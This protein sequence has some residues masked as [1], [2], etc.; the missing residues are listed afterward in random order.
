LDESIH[1]EFVDRFDKNDIC[2][3][4]EPA[5]FAMCLRFRNCRCQMHTLQGGFVLIAMLCGAGIAD[6]AGEHLQFA[7]QETAI[8]SSSPSDSAAG[9]TAAE[10][11]CPQRI[12]DPQAVLTVDIQPVERP[13]LIELDPQSLPKECPAPVMAGAPTLFVGVEPASLRRWPVWQGA[14]FCHRPLYF[15]EACAERCGC[16]C[17]CAPAAS[18]AHFFGSAILLPLRM[19]RQCPGSCV[20]T[21][22]AF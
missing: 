2:L 15:E 10:N 8:D 13:G 4:L 12:D 20:C 21:P 11:E 1:G 17:C 16:T 14:Q 22:P 5:F 7:R 19:C 3:S 6:G 18:A 9:D